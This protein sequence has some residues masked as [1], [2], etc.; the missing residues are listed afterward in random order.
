MLPETTSS[1]LLLHPPTKEIVEPFDYFWRKGLQTVS[2]DKPIEQTQFRN[3]V[4][5]K[6]M[7]INQNARN[8]LRPNFTCKNENCIGDTG[9]AHVAMRNVPRSKDTTDEVYRSEETTLC[10]IGL[11][12]PSD[13]V[14][15]K[16]LRW[17][18]R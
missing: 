16:T 15:K 11:P 14:A 6:Y 7:E 9:L 5:S 1:Y 12:I 3:T 8:A 4:H 17:W 2:T 10:R 18:D 13:S